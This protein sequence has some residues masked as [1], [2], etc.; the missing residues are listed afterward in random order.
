VPSGWQHGQA[1][2]RV[3]SYVTDTRPGDNGQPVTRT[4]RSNPAAPK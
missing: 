3:S 1:L 4:W 2:E